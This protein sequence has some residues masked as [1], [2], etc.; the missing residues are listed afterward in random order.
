MKE[1]PKYFIYR[2]I[3]NAL[4]FFSYKRFLWEK[5]RTKAVEALNYI[6]NQNNRQGVTYEML[7][8]Q[9]QKNV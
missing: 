3:E 5:N 2:N 4:I 7:E 8:I 6:A 1:S 9:K